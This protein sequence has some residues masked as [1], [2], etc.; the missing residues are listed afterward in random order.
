MAEAFLQSF[1]K[2]LIVESAG[3]VPAERVNPNAIQV[4]KELGIDI[5]NNK[6]KVV[7]IFLNE[8]WDWVITVCG[9]AR[10][11]CPAFLGKVKN[12][13][14]IG[15]DDPAEFQGT[16]EETLNEF[17]RIRDEIKKEFQN[18]YHKDILKLK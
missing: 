9:G 10:E 5:S 15:F 18:F 17:R 4:M 14:H 12:R 11:T 7:D 1:D 16:K 6:T 2:N 13:V 3:T 8:E